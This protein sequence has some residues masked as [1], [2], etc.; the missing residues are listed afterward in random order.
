MSVVVRSRIEDADAKT[1]EVI[2]SEMG[3]NMSEFL[4]IAVKQLNNQKA[5]PFEM[6]ITNPETLQ[7]ID[8]MNQ[9]REV[10]TFPSFDDF[11]AN[12]VGK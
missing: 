9:R 1:A 6:V 5:L 3:M 8:D 11:K 12:F 2:L 10:V 7:A 4:R